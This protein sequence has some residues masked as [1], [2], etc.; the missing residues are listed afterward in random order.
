MKSWRLFTRR[1]AAFDGAQAVLWQNVAVVT[2]YSLGI[3]GLG[4][5]WCMKYS[6]HTV[7]AQLHSSTSWSPSQA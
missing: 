6:H 5:I 7:K 1:I 3:V 4:Y 2:L